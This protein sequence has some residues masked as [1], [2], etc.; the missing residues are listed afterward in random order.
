MI[1]DDFTMPRSVISAAPAGNRTVLIVDDDPDFLVLVDCLLRREYRVM[2]ADCGKEAIR[3]AKQ[4][5]P[6]VVLLDLEMPD[7]TGHEVCRQLKS[8]GG[9]YKVQVVMVSARSSEEEQLRA[10]AEGADDYVIKPIDPHEFPARVRLHF[11]LSDAME[12]AGSVQS[13]IESHHAELRTKVESQRQRLLETQDVAVFT[14]AA[15]ADSRDEV[16][17]KHLLRMREY[18]QIIAN[19]LDAGGR[20]AHLI[21]PQFLDDLYRSSPLHDIGKVAVPDAI[22]RKPG[23]L[24]ADEFQ[25]MKQHTVIGANILDQAVFHSQ[26][27]GFLAMAAI[28]ARFHH[29]R[30]DGQGYPAG[31]VGEEI[32]LPARIVAV[33]DVYD[34]LTSDRPYRKA[35]SSSDACEIVRAGAGSH[36]DSLVVDAFE[37]CYSA[38]TE[39]QFREQAVAPLALGAVS[40]QSVQNTLWQPTF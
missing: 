12:T 36:F 27:G 35:L 16:T 6:P 14:L 15:I 30:Y 40:F 13:Q 34:A 29:E 24:T 23:P 3:L 4:F 11:R 2:T 18:S 38:I 28:I 25:L 8:I 9:D 17:G 32:P 33:A 26:S 37:D 21:G 10:F 22:L 1:T 19:R 39:V 5:R 20:H 7:T 31:L